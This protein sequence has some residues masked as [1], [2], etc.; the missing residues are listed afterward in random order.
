MSR[1]QKQWKQRGKVLYKH[2]FRQLSKSYMKEM[3]KQVNRSPQDKMTKTRKGGHDMNLVSVGKLPSMKIQ[4]KTKEME[5][6]H[7]CLLDVTGG[8]GRIDTKTY[9]ISTIKPSENCKV[10]HLKSG[11]NNLADF[12]AHYICV[13]YKSTIVQV[14]YNLLKYIFITV[15]GLDL[16]LDLYTLYTIIIYLFKHFRELEDGMCWLHTGVFY[17]VSTMCHLG[18]KYKI[19]VMK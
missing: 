1:L 8:L 16:N 18:T 10:L 9:E 3:I 19:S 4:M 17:H 11:H 15:F 14:M 6:L 7:V 5:N 2:N 12:I 13:K